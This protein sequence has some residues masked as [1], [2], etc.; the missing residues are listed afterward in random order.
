[1]V[2]GSEL[3]LDGVLIPYGRV[4]LQQGVLSGFLESGQ[5]FSVSFYHAGISHPD[6]FVGQ[7]LGTIHTTAQVEQGVP[8][9]SGAGMAVLVAVLSLVGIRVVCRW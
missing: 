2:V 6:C 1:V 8:A 4:P 3:R 9:L 5:P 7:C